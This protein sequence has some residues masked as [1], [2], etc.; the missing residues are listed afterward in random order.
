MYSNEKYR[1][2]II[3]FKNEATKVAKFIPIYFRF[4]FAEMDKI[5]I[6]SRPVMRQSCSHVYSAMFNAV[7]S[8]LFIKYF[9][10]SSLDSFE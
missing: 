9:G 1:P 6:K 7:R 5:V 4:R 3:L 2:R 8:E 10:Y